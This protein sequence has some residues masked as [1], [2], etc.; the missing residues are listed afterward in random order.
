M[1]PDGS[2]VVRLTSSGLLSPDGRQILSQTE[3]TP[4]ECSRTELFAANADGSNPRPLTH[5]KIPDVNPAW[6]HDGKKIA[7]TTIPGVD[8]TKGAICVINADGSGL[9]RLTDQSLQSQFSSWSPD[10]TRI[11]F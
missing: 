4:G 5:N 7:F 3:L 2:E 11:A 10:G 9:A 1:K 8:W 6:S